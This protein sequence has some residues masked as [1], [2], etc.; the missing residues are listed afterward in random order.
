MPLS[1][2]RFFR[3]QRIFRA[4]NE[5]VKRFLK[6]LLG[7]LLSLA[8]LAILG[9]WFLYSRDYSGYFQEKRG[10]LSAVTVEAAGR[11]SLFQKSWV[12]LRSTSGLRVMSG[13]L[14]PSHAPGVGGRG[15]PAVRYPAVIVL[16]GKATGKYAVDY[17]LDI[18]NVI[19]A[20]P[21]YPYEPRASYTTLEAL[22]EVPAIRSAVID[23]MPS[24][25]LLMDYLHTRRDVDTTRI[26][27]LG[28]SFGAPFV[29]CIVAN[30]RRAAIAA[31]V[32]GGGDVASLIGHN[33]ARYRSPLLAG[34][35]GWL[36]GILLHPVEPLRYVGSVSPIPVLMINGTE[37]EQVPRHNAELLFEGAREPKR[38]VWIESRHV[39]P[40]NIELTRQIVATLKSELARMKIVPES[41]R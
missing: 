26:I 15:T 1:V 12:T 13:M 27:L 36:A 9:G 16:G 32:Y 29:P 20:A 25:M 3:I 33:I 6:S 19:I 37:D 24:V 17:A 38:I 7:L 30:D 40:R 31:M 22:A 23:M 10:K 14:V 5:E 28:Y 21:D 4:R 18:E 35:G 34:I 11:D 39:H 8:A 41:P 2:L